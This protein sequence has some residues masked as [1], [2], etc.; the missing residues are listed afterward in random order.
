MGS[1]VCYCWAETHYKCL[2]LQYLWYQRHARVA[3][4]SQQLYTPFSTKRTLYKTPILYNF[5]DKSTFYKLLSYTVIWF[6]IWKDWYIHTLYL[7]GVSAQLRANRAHAQLGLFNGSLANGAWK[8]QLSGASRT[9]PAITNIP[10][11]I[12]Y[13]GEFLTAATPGKTTVMRSDSADLLAKNHYFIFNY[14][15]F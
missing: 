8:E 13:S 7:P 2:Y 6:T 3:W 15:I 1:C 9:E 11:N 14:M 5:P 12:C 4:E 10:C